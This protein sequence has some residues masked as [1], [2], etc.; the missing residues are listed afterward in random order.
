MFG[1]AKTGLSSDRMPG[2]LAK[3]SSFAPRRGHNAVLNAFP[4]VGGNRLA[5]P[6]VT[7]TDY[8]SQK[9]RWRLMRIAQRKHVKQCGVECRH[10][11]NSRNLYFVYVKERRRIDA[12]PVALSVELVTFQLRHFGGQNE[13][14]LV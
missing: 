13:K 9:F 7:I 3:L 1:H 5:K 14:R 12:T 2:H 10:D 11:T 6:Y 4:M 8:A